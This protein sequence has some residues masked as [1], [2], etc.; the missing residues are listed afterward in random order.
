VL[1]PALA[2]GGGLLA[3]GEALQRSGPAVLCCVSS[4]AFCLP[5]GAT[6]LDLRNAS[7]GLP[8]TTLL[9]ALLRRNGTLTSLSLS[10]SYLGGEA[11]ARLVSE[12]AA[13]SPVLER[14]S[15]DGGAL[16]VRQ[17]RGATGDDA[18]DLSGKRLG[19]DSAE[20]IG[21]MLATNTVL[22]TLV[23]RD[24]AIGNRGAHALAAA[25]RRNPTLTALDVR[26]NGWM[27][28]KTVGL[29][30]KLVRLRST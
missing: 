13:R 27:H 22:K 4:D 3:L 29:L 19:P 2:A 10:R 30:A 8:A 23:L 15:L 24:N 28:E 21:A 5:E 11:G 9:A 14:L 6:A 12:A 25:L 16:P 17:L 7:L 18:L 1:R 26:E 20:A